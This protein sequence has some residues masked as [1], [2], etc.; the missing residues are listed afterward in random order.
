MVCWQLGI[1][2]VKACNV[3]GSLNFQSTDNDFVGLMV[4]TVISCISGENAE[5]VHLSSSAIE[6]ADGYIQ[7]LKNVWM[8][9]SCLT[10]QTI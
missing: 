1:K 2:V 8:H 4:L 6:E 10:S 9:I 5:S 3:F 7:G